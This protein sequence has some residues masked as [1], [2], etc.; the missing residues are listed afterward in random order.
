M[1]PVRTLLSLLVLGS[2]LMAADEGSKAPRQKG[3]KS[4]KVV[5]AV[6]ASDAEDVA[7]FVSGMNMQGSEVKVRKTV[8]PK[9]N[10]ERFLVLT[11]RGPVVVQAYINIDK[12]PFRTL[13]EAIV[14]DVLK[15]ADTD[16]DGKPTWK[17]AEAN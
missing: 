8:D 12:K 17:E 2:L 14:D 13:R 5:A 4:K 11:P 3:E 10:R 1:S 16:G 7:V 9:D 6:K 15:L